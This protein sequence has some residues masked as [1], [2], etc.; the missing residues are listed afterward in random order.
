[1]LRTAPFRLILICLTGLLTTTLLAAQEGPLEAYVHQPDPAYGYQVVGQLPG[2][3]FDAYFLNMNSQNW[4][5]SNEVTPTLW[6]HWVTLIVPH[7]LT[8][9]TANLIITGE[10]FSTTPPSPEG[11]ALYLPLATYTGSIQVVVQQIPAQPVQFADQDQPT[12]EDTIV[13][14]SWRKSMQTGDPTW[15]VMLP[16]TKA[17]VRAMDT[18]QDYLNETLGLGIQHRTLQAGRHCLADRGGGPQ[19]NRGG[20]G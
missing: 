19:S 8:S 2:G 18:A 3:D 16:M 15:A 13:S 1:M 7:N 17:S 9:D 11:L 10:K 6:N 12:L 4:R 14:L 20:A 5:S